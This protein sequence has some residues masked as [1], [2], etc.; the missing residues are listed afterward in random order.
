MLVTL[1][2]AQIHTQKVR[3]GALDFVFTVTE[4]PTLIPQLLSTAGR[5]SPSQS[6]MLRRSDSPHKQSSLF[7]LSPHK[8]KSAL[9]R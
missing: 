8:N 6:D 1:E 4:K 2:P 3:S 5:G 9:K 7:V